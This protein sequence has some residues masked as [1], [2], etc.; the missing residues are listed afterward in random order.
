MSADTA[1]DVSER[2]AICETRL[3]DNAAACTHF[4]R[5]VLEE[6]WMPLEQ[7]EAL[8]VLLGFLVMPDGFLQL[9]LCPCWLSGSQHVCLLFTGLSSSSKVVQMCADCHSSLEVAKLSEQ[10][11]KKQHKLH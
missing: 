4:W 3:C 10:P 8:Q 11:E 9:L 6:C 5:H 2:E 7:L 1:T